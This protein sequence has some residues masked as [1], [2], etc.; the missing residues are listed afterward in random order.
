MLLVDAAG[1]HLL[2]SV[3]SQGVRVL[4]RYAAEPELP[5]AVPAP[6]F[7]QALAR[8]RGEAQ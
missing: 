5:E 6:S 7:G 2:L 1:A 4:H 3:G 8:M